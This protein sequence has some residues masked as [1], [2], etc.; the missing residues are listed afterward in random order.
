MGIALRNPNDDG[1]RVYRIPGLVTTNKGTLIAV[2]DIRYHGWGDL[3]G[4]IDVGMSVLD[5]WRTY[6]GTDEEHHG[7]GC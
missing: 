4:N 1:A 6:L 5:R 2:Y 3:P 7:H